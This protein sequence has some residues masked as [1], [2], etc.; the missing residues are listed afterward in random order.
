MVIVV[1]KENVIL[2]EQR[3]FIGVANKMDKRMGLIT[4]FDKRR[5]EIISRVY[6]KNSGMA[7]RCVA[8]EAEENI[9]N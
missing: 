7:C 9:A 3:G 5:Q 4:I 1:L 8:D 2:L 6:A